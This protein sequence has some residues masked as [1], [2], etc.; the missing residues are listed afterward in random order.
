MKR[1]DRSRELACA[2]RAARAA[3]ALLIRHHL[4]SKVVCE[5]SQHDIK[6]ELDLRCQAI[7]ERCLRAAYPDDSI[8]G[9]E[10]T[11][12]E[13]SAPYRWVVDPIDGTVNFAH[14]IPHACVSIALQTR[15]EPESRRL[16]RSPSS[17]AS[18]DEYHTLIG[19]VLDPFTR[20]LWTAVRGG[21][22]RLNGRV[23]RVSQRPLRESI[24]AMGFAKT[25]PSL[26]LTLPAFNG[27]VHRVRKIRILGAAALDLAYVAGGRLDAFV[28]SGLRLWDIAAG[29][30]MVECAGGNYRAEPL[31]GDFTYRVRAS[32]QPTGRSL[33]RL[34]F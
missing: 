7:I 33:H 34:G 22:T 18:A 14:G 2:V 13:A 27:L 24:V 3:G 8:L 17:P 10:G 15:L 32:N 29:G 5:V 1:R 4:S 20:E 19:V 25:R 26:E 30:L 28:E 12:G 6:L 9:E 31:P 23:V 11:Q 21:K 16:A